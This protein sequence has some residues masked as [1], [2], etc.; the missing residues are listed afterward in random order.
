MLNLEIIAQILEINLQNLEIT[1]LQ[2]LEI[3]LQ[4]LETICKIWRSFAKFGDHFCTNFGDHCTKFG[5]HCTNFGDHRLKKN[6]KNRRPNC[7]NA[8]KN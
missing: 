4:N 6:I 8:V 7:F 2:N 5:D 1:F 3:N